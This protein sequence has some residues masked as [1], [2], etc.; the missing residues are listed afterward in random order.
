[1]IDVKPISQMD[2]KW[3]ND[4]LGFANDSTIGKFGCLLTSMTMVANTYGFNETPATVN[5]KMRNVGGF[6][7][8]YIIP[9]LLPKALPG[10]IYRNFIRCQNQPAPLTEIDA[11]LA[12]GKPVII[13]VDYSPANG[14]QNHWVVLYGK[15]GDDYLMRDPWP[16]PAETKEVTLLSRFGFAGNASETITA[17]VWLDGQTSSSSA[18]SAPPPKPRTNVVASFP[19]YATADDL[20]MR[21]QTVVADYTLIKRVPINTAFDVLLTDAEANQKVGV[22][23]QWLPVREKSTNE[24]GWVAA[25]YVSKSKQTPPPP[26]PPTPPPSGGAFIVRSLADGL[27]LRTRPEISDATL[28]KRL[29]LNAEM[30]SLEPEANAR[31]KIG[32]MYQW[33]K[34][35]DAD[36]TE[37]VVAAWYVEPAPGQATIGATAQTKRTPTILSADEEV[38]PLIIRASAENL[39]LRNLP[40][41]A[42]DTLRI[43]LPLDTE[44]IVLEDPEKAEEKVGRMGEWLRVR[45]LQ[46]NEGYVAAWYTKKRPEP[47]NKPESVPQDC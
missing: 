17:V 12:A 21:N 45:D 42:P 40:Y 34:V 3:K 43:R 4:L 16:N 22:M 30:R 33:L 9:A 7:G 2:P 37:G 27:A 28:I 19:V 5:E 18:S 36:G 25:W 14:M 13:E 1:M 39:A 47:S 23:N 29:P 35:R 26:P 24:V 41:I 20:A 10:I 44:M 6:Q 15:K 31:A 8:A 32:V 46:G 38:P 11:A